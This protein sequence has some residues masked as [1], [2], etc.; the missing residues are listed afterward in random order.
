MSVIGQIRG[1]PCAFMVDVKRAAVRERTTRTDSDVHATR[2]RRDRGTTAAQSLGSHPFVVLSLVVLAMG[3]P[4]ARDLQL[5]EAREDIPNGFVLSGPA[6]P[7]TTLNLRIALAPSDTPGLHKALYDV[8]TPGSANYGRHLSKTEVEKFAAPKPESVDAVNAWLKENNIDARTISPAGD[9]MAFDVSV[10]KANELFSSNFSVYKHGG[11]G[12]ET[13][14]T[15]SYSIPASLKDHLDLV[16][17]TI[18]FP[19]PQPGLPARISSIS[20]IVANVTSGDILSFCSGSVTPSCLQALYGIPTTNATQSSSQLAVTGLLDQFANKVDL[21]T[22]LENFR[23][24]IPSSTTFTFQAVDGGQ[25]NQDPTQAGIEAD[26]DIQYTV[27]LATGVPI[28]FISVG[29]ETTDGVDGLL[30]IINFLLNESAPPHVLTTSYGANE[31]DFSRMLANSVCNA[32]AQLGA[33]GTSILF[34]SG[35]GGVSGSQFN[36]KCIK[37]FIPT[38]PSGCPFITSVGATAGMNPEAAAFY[39]SGGFSNYFGVPPYQVDEHSA[40]LDALGH[41][42]SDRY[43]ASGRGFPDVSTQG[44]NFEIVVAGKIQ[45]VQG[46]SCASP[47]FASIISLVNDKLVAKGRSPLGFLNPLLYSPAGKAAF[48]DIT[49]GNNPGCLTVGFPA[50][51]GWDPV[52]GLGTPVFSKLLTAAGL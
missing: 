50:Q 6:A 24:D 10:S 21:E 16:H 47:T 48:T 35:D 19:S 28:V 34:S 7:D 1:L 13:I 30:D 11:T 49:F 41:T 29:E 39:S 36:P 22:F 8:S 20:P 46:T 52:T 15:L 18:S 5:H 2:V 31:G 40:Y 44:T 4:M 42:Y 27:G 12:M 26:L 32:Y 45:S 23:T 9:W 43:N 3:K 14:R 33:R 51:S 25:N 38:F 37:N 17:P